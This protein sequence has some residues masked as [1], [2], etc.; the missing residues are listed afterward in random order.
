MEADSI[1]IF[2]LK[3]QIQNQLPS[4]CDVILVRRHLNKLDV[5]IHRIRTSKSANLHSWVTCCAQLSFHWLRPDGVVAREDNEAQY[6]LVHA[7]LRALF[8]GF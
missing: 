7:Q 5:K 3:T 2:V 6:T 4:L 1:I 8:I